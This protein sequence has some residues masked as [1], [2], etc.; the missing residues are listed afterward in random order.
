MNKFLMLCAIV[1][2][3]LGTTPARAWVKF[4]NST[5]QVVFVATAAS[6][7]SGFGCGWDDGC[8]GDGDPKTKGWWRL[9][10][11]QTKTVSSENWGNALW[12]FHAVGD[13]GLV[14]TGDD[15]FCTENTAFSLCGGICNTNQIVRSFRNIRGS[16]CCGGFCPSDHTIN[17]TD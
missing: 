11:N 15:S 14:W 6:S 16:R 8:S 5:D 13:N 17:L 4:K 7:V 12:W 3:I 2:A 9:E 10:P 1:V